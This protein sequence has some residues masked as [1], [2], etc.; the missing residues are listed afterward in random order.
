LKKEI[1]MISQYSKKQL[2][3]ICNNCGKEILYSG[4]WNSFLLILNDL[5]WITLKIDRE[6]RN[7]CGTC[8]QYPYI[9]RNTNE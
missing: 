9:W 7:Y 1:K 3:A 5:G 8:K 6:L 2:K 4:D